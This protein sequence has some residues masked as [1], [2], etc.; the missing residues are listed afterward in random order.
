M[1]YAY[2]ENRYTRMHTYALTYSYELSHAEPRIV[3]YQGMELTVVGLEIPC[4]CSWG[5]QARLSEWLNV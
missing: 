3:S 1:I 2:T 5:S 4:T